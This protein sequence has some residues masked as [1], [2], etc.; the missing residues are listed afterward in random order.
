MFSLLSHQG[1]ER[2]H[3]FR[4]IILH[5]SKWLGP[6]TQVT[7]HAGK[8]VEQGEYSSIAGGNAKLYNHYG[9]QYGCSPRKLGIILP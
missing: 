1:N 7:A 5:S 8:D 6:I 4:D 3:Y 2:Q 9:N